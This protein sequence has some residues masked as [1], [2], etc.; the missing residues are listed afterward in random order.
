MATLSLRI[1][2]DGM[3]GFRTMQFEPSTLVFDACNIIRQKIPECN[4]GN[5]ND[6]GLFLADED[7][8]K[9]VW[10]DKKHTLEYYLLRNQDLLEYKKKL[11]VLRVRTLDESVKAMYV[12][13]S[14]PV[15]QLMITICSR[16]GIT[17]HDEY[18]LVH[19]LGED[20]KMKTLT[21]KRDKSI[22]K[23]QKK[24]E[25]MKKKLH[26]DDEL[27][28]LDH[29][30]TLREQGIEESETLLLR[31]KFFFSDQ[32]VD[33]RD[34]V[35]LNLLY[36]QTRDAILKGAH[37]VSEK[38]AIFFAA[39]QCQIQF[40]DHNESKHKP[41]FLDL[42]EFMPKEYIKNK[43]IEKAIY[44]EHKTLV[45]SNLSE[46]D[47]KVKYTQLARSLKT[48]G[49]TFFL[50]KEKV[51]GKNKLVPR[52]LG[53]TKQNV[54]RVDHKT[55]EILKQWDLTSVKRWAASP[56][57]FTLDFGD[58]S[59]E[60]YSVQ[61]QEGEQISQL[62]AGYI[63]II[64]KKKKAAE[65]LGIDGNEESFTYEDEVSPA[66]ATII[67]HQSSKMGQGQMGSVALPAVLRAGE[68]GQNHVSHGSMQK[69]QFSQVSQPAHVGHVAPIG[70]S[71][72][73]HGLSQAQRALLGTIDTGLRTAGRAQ[74]DLDTK[75][76]LPTLGSDPASR[77]WVQNQ[78]DMSRAN[79]GA[80]MSAMN[81]ATAGIVTGTGQDEPDY[82][83]V[84]AAVSTI[85]ANLPEF[86]KDARL[87]AALYEDDE[88]GNKLLDAARRLA[89]AFTDLLKAAQP[90]SDQPRQNLLNAASK[91]GEASQDIMTRVEDTNIENREFEDM[92]LALA[93]A[94]ANA[95]AS[96]VLKAKGVAAETNSQDDQNAMIG[97]ATQCALATS[98]LVA[99][100]KVVAPTIENPACQ[101][102]L[103]DSAKI[104]A[105]SV[106]H[107]VNTAENVS[108]HEG[109]KSDLRQAATAVSRALDDLL[110]HIRRGA[111]SKKVEEV[112]VILNA[113]DQLFNSMGDTPE[114]VRQARILAQAT[115][116]LVN[117][118]KSEA[119]ASPDS[120]QQKK[121][122]AAAK[123]LADATARMVEAA[124]GCASKPGDRSQQEVLRQAADDLRSA[125]SVATAE[126]I[127]KQVIKNLELAAR[128][129]ASAAT[130]CIN[131]SAS[132]N[133]CNSSTTAQQQLFEHCKYVAD[134]VIPRLVQALR[135]SMRNPDSSSAHNQL[136][137]A[138]QEMLNPGGKLVGNARVAIPT[139]TDQ[140][141]ANSLNNAAQNLSAA[142]TELRKAAGQAQ[143]ACGQQEID[144][145]LDQ[146]YHLEKEIDDYR[147]AAHQRALRPLPGETAENS[148]TQLGATSKT[149]GSSM[150][151]LLTAAAQG[152]DNYTGIAAKDTA[153]SLRVLTQAVRG[154]AATSSDIELQNRI[155]L[156]AKDVMDKSS[157]LIE[158]A[159]KAVNN[160]NNPEN[161][162]RLAQ[163]AKAV[164]QSLK[165]CVDCLP[166]LKEV[167]EA[168]RQ[169]N[170]ISQRL[171]SGD[172]PHTDRSYQQVQIDLNNR[173][174]TLNKAAT[175]IV[176]AS[177]RTPQDVAGASSQFS[178]AYGDFME[179][180]MEMGA[181]TK[182]KETKTQIVTG[183]RSVS[184]TSSKLLISTKSFMTDPNAPNA[185]N[186]L[187]QAARQVTDSINHLIDVCTTAAPGQKECDSAL[188][189]MMAMRPLLE[190][191]CEPI[192]DNS[193]FECMKG[194]IAGAKTLAETMTGISNHAKF[195]QLE[196]FCENVKAFAGGVCSIT[197][198]SAQAAYLVG[199][200][201]PTSQPGQVGLV[202]QSQFARANQAIQMACS[203]LTDPA[204]TQQQVLSA[205]TI[206]AKHTSS[207]CNTCRV[208]SSKTSNPVAKRHFV[209][210]A[211]DVANSTAN[212]VRAIKA[213]DSDFTDENRQRCA[214]AS[215]PLLQ[216]VDQLTT[217]ASS[218][219]F[220][221]VPAKISPRARE[222]QEPIAGAGLSLI[223]GA[224]NMVMAAKNLAVNPK[225]PPTYQQYSSHSH[226]VSEAIKRL[227]SSIKDSA[228]GQKECDQAIA[229]INKALRVI[230]QASMN[231]VSQN[232]APR[233]ENTLKGFEEQI[234]RSAKEML[235]MVDNVRTA[236]KQEA[237]K[238]GH[239]VT[240]FASYIE[241]IAH[242]A[243][244][245][246][247][248]INNS[249]RQERI[250]DE[251]KT[252]AESVL[253]LTIACK[254]GGGNP[255]QQHQSID[256][257]ADTV[258]DNL[259]EYIATLEEAASSAGIVSTMVESINKAITK[260][261]DKLTV[262][263]RLAYADFQTNMV[264]LAKQIAQTSQ[265]IATKA[266][267]DVGQ[268]GAAAN[269]LTKDY[270]MLAD[271]CRGAQATAFNYETG[272]KIKHSVQELGKCCVNLVQ[273]AGNVYADP[274]DS[275]AKRDLQQHSK[276]VN[277]QVA[278]VLT[279]LQA[280]AQGTQACINASHTVSGII[281]DLDTTIM[282]ATAGT[283]NADSGDT[284]SDHREN[285]LK[286]AKALVE[287]TK[288]LVAG[289]A[290]N[291]EQL[292][293]AAQSAVSTIT[294]LADCVKLG[295]A[296]LGA[297]QP[298][299]QVLLINAVKDVAAALGELISA[300]K[301]ASGKSAQDPAMGHLKDSAKVMVTNV[302]SLL[303]TVKTVEDETARGTRALESSIEAIGQ[304][305]RTYVS[306]DHVE[307]EVSAEELIRCTK[308]ITVATA[309]AVAAGNSGLQDDVIV[310]ANMGRK[311][312]A[313]LLKACKG[314]SLLADSEDGRRRVLGVGQQCSE[315]YRELLESVHMAIQKPTP[316]TKQKLGLVSK[317]VATA[318]TQIVH[319]AEMLK[320]TDWV[321]PADPTVIAETE[322]LS[323]ANQIEAA[324]KKLAML[325]P[326]TRIAPRQAD[327][328]LNFEEQILE[329]AKSIAAATAALVKAANAAQRELVMQGKVGG[330]YSSDSD[331]QW[332]EGLI[333]AAR[334]VAAATHSL[335]EA[336]NAMVQGNGSEETLI[337]A[338]KQVAS[339]T[340]QLL[341]ACKVKADVDSVAM[342]R[343]Q[344]A[345][346]AVKRATEALV[347]AAQQAAG[348]QDPNQDP[349]MVNQRMVGGLAQIIQA[350]EAI[351]IKERELDSA[352]RKLE[353][354][355]KTKYKNR[356][357]DYDSG[358]DF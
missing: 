96:L 320:G 88:D 312:V 153:N 328:E 145:A 203:N 44:K 111:R 36:V 148:A 251:S 324:A 226:S 162:T 12:D 139:I 182:E 294:R 300:T 125:T 308:P 353:I 49:I 120:E 245:A 204:A 43:S 4:Q 250:L 66:K 273:D 156:S 355:R 138:S 307:K 59:D 27:N 42:K 278:Q 46:V 19:E 186:L 236:G 270:R 64:L 50:V 169:L 32:N 341:V 165:G 93:K 331:S 269:Q 147:H 56:N 128:N 340:A 187:T 279:A 114:M 316:G 24:L 135:G 336:A 137:Q 277:E 281:G 225:D 304:D 337:S 11:R 107:V 323:A 176:S 201:D 175:D 28:W 195:G 211:K 185:K 127:K 350:Q 39:L 345:G 306:T 214:E 3:D 55:K 344:S 124:K 235:E 161:Q 115:S 22:A 261:E 106:D 309:K 209:Q 121:L 116:Q 52:L 335:C 35:Q 253:Q 86:S 184:M 143:E 94:V 322:L 215:R 293:R 122:L 160:P 74:N 155:L 271:Q 102:Q 157:K 216:A 296:S 95:T 282:F 177:Q 242:G 240:Q 194:V 274:S 199:V 318:V 61:T 60:Y 152:N 192:S 266:N 103:I 72:Q 231:A 265:T 252:V 200:S 15:G 334:M 264:R 346:N 223:D 181:V 1:T 89:N 284:F 144:A 286:T 65:Y 220:T 268:L 217:F 351:L 292:A 6:F 100:T 67:Q 174:I 219:E 151:Q 7:P 325:Q 190:N 118:L 105:R 68:P 280:G 108:D 75:A 302:T 26:T 257:C 259:Q 275:L 104:V 79:I 352:R 166:G 260:T 20:E 37:P 191:P 41:G 173:A 83:A 130:Q 71:P 53:V 295:A 239:L 159:K 205:A 85:S 84:G 222:A 38:E 87:L 33:A 171:A 29:S 357:V 206:V 13:D 101:E 347:T 305:I 2:T 14:V 218:P 180:G 221:S 158:E 69:A 141:V 333:S 109:T 301:N 311:A 23:D 256:D 126:T 224:C 168:L 210:S 315:S 303:K 78:R 10:L 326:R 228:P 142:L 313:D 339:S 76:E 113:T 233:R 92:L 244:G 343:L 247:S 232:L 48:Y 317:N 237:E 77:K 31:R 348:T 98:Q 34:P 70:Q 117:A 150:A 149:V 197:E 51:K 90:G 110:Q 258:R 288:T 229:K 358:S 349:L 178:Q 297:E 17:N 241:P 81:A 246:A 248:N 212:L 263:D 338:A 255:Q 63:D 9:G 57:S 298:E 321:D 356:P 207:L 238:L 243:V 330:A 291:Q 249:K 213:L 154:V 8:K 314:A 227:V 299:A 262:T 283:L 208:A 183:L 188:R 97:S 230:E 332:S 5:P 285:I 146:V 167:D 140:A 354:I 16:M 18:S 58:Y 234:I 272:E 164:S 45:G 267:T 132:A 329:A 80:Q 179:T 25:E 54:V 287:D 193:Y 289:A 136:I 73:V 276:L 202:D 131:A 319:T 119:E 290:S 196:E 133:D 112:H 254:E 129:A 91:I 172:F 30:K 163:V 123:A 21:M 198:N 47:A 40:G 170:S 134:E 189:Q 99:C 310:A 327:E 342:R 82:N 62:I